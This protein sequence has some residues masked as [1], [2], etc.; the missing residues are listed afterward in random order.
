MTHWRDLDWEQRIGAAFIFVLAVVF[1]TL[2]LIC[3][4][5]EGE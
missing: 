5:V 1:L 2:I 4:W 3:E